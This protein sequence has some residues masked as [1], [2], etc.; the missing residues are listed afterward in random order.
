[1]LYFVPAWYKQNK[2]CE[3]EQVWYSRR[4]KSEF[5]ETI[6]QITLFHRNVDVHRIS[7]IFSTD[8]ECTDPDTGH[9]LTQ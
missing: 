5:D 2:W 9:V 1:M 3:N 7:D 4:M 8:R 6:K